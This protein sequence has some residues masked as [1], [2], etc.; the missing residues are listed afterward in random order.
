[1]AFNDPNNELWV[2]LAE[3]AYAQ[4]NEMGWARSGSPGSGVNSYN[5]I[6]VGAVGAGLSVVTGLPVVYTMVSYN[7]ASL[8]DFETVWNAGKMIGFAS[9][10]VP[11]DSRLAGLHSYAAIGYDPTTKSVTLFNPWGISA[12]L[13]TLTWSEMTVNFYGYH[14][15][16]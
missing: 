7:P 1:M 2:A 14:R 5:A 13:I 9:W 3:K 15:T 11:T 16:A 8:N 10:S 6:S 4:L 12:G